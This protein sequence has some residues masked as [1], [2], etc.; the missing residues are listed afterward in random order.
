MPRSRRYIQRLTLANIKT[1][2]LDRG[3]QRGDLLRGTGASKDGVGLP[4]GI[5]SGVGRRELSV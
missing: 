5:G 3:A 1:G 2:P 4:G